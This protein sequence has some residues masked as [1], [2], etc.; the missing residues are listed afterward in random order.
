MQPQRD[1]KQPVPRAQMHT[2]DDPSAPVPVQKP[3]VGSL[4]GW[5]HSTAMCRETAPAAVLQNDPALTST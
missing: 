2:R 5:R 3:Q 1:A 4:S